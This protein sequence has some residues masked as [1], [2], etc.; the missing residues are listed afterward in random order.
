MRR[1]NLAVDPKRRNPRLQEVTTETPFGYHVGE[2]TRVGE[3]CR[4][5]VD[6]EKKEVSVVK[7][8]TP[9][10]LGQSAASRVQHPDESCFR[11]LALGLVVDG[12]PHGH[13]EEASLESRK[14][15]THA[16]C[17]RQPLACEPS[18]DRD[19]ITI[20][21]TV[22][23]AIDHREGDRRAAPPRWRRQLPFV[24]STTAVS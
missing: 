20:V 6:R 12:G 8:A 21:G 17:E 18:S 16:G 5:L 4:E 10:Q 11:P 2:C 9:R 15:R 14:I 7:P 23:K 13:V 3:N 19:R 24:G 1:W 22:P